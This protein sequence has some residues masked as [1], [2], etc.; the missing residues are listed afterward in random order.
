MHALSLFCVYHNL[1]LQN[2]GNMHDVIVLLWYVLGHILNIFFS[3]FSNW[4]FTI[5]G[6]FLVYVHIDMDYDA[7]IWIFE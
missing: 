4:L 7:L 2:A 1:I 3:K 6:L 5:N